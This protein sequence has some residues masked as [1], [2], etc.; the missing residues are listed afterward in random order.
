MEAAAMYDG[1]KIVSGL[2][3]FLLIATFP[4]WYSSAAGTPG[5]RPQ[6]EL[7]AGEKQCVENREY[8][9]SSHMTLLDQ[10]RDAFVREN[11][12]MYTSVAYGEQYEASLTNTCLKCHQNRDTFCDRCHE[13]ADIDPYCWDCHIDKEGNEP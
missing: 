7:P 9:L 2:V 11:E 1:G 13:Y 3:V 8:M 5:E 6:P 12:R 10:W 4:F